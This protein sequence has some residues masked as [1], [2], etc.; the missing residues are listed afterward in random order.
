MIYVPTILEKASRSNSPQI[1]KTAN[2]VNFN[3]YNS[4]YKANVYYDQNT[5]AEHIAIMKGNLFNKENVLVRV[6]S[7]C[8]TSETF[9]CIK[10]ECRQQLRQ[11]FELIDQNE[12]AIIYLDQEGR[13]IGLGA[14]LRAY[15][16]QEQGFDSADA[17]LA[18]GAEI[19]TRNYE[20]AAQ[21]IEDLR[22]KSIK[23][24]T[25]NPDKVNQLIDHGINVTQRVPHRIEN[26]DTYYQMKVQKLGHVVNFES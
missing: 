23:L 6:H 4:N 2:Y 24:L 9:E 10:C 18:I 1:I 8:Q 19:D 17:N 12:G 13:G 7:K 25:N 14:K 20:V 15:Q 22:F 26:F 3:A 16:L 21:I 5:N 11:A